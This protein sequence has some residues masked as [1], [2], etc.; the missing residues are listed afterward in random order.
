MPDGMLIEIA[1]DGP[2][3]LVDEPAE[4]LGQGLALPPWLEPER[5]TLESAL[6]P[7]A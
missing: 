5:E 6:A 1:T 4:S 3:F 7:I 2:G